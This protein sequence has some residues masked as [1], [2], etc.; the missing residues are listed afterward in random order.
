MPHITDDDGVEHFVPAAELE[1]TR[2]DKTSDG[3]LI[4]YGL[5]VFTNNCRWGT[6]IGL[7]D[8]MQNDIGWWNL[9]EDGTDGP[10]TML[11]GSRMAVR[12]NIGFTADKVRVEE[13][14]TKTEG[15]ILDEALD[16]VKHNFPVLT[17]IERAIAVDSYM[18]GHKFGYERRKLEEKT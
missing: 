3:V 1:K 13:P 2:Q 15:D 12:D 14:E 6:V 17:G 4:K 16:W 9:I 18:A 10:P 11:D 5:R 8:V 7:C